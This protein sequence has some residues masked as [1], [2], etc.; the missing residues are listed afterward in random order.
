MELYHR[1]YFMNLTPKARKVKAK[2]MRLY[3]KLLHSKRN[4]K[5]KR[6]P[7]GWEMVFASNSSDKGLISGFTLF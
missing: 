5:T 7:M 2:I 4:N 3:A 1:E 6:Q